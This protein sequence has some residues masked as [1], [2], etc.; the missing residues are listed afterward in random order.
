MTEHKRPQI[1]SVQSDKGQKE[2]NLAVPSTPQD[3]PPTF[4][5]SYEGLVAA[6]VR[7]FMER[8]A[9]YRKASKGSKI[10]VG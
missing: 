9:D 6:D 1:G 2:P 5:R 10:L 3:G 7:E 4:E 8:A